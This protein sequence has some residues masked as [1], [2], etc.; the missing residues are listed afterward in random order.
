MYVYQRIIVRCTV[1]GYPVRRED[2]M[3]LFHISDLHLGIKLGGR[4]ISEDMRAI[5]L[6]GVLGTAYEKYRPD[7][8][9]IAGDI[10]DRRTPPEE[11]VALFDEFMHKA[12]GLSLPLYMISGNHDSAERVAYGRGLFG[13]CGVHIS[14]P[15]SDRPPFVSVV[16]AGGVDIA[17]LPNITTEAVNAWFPDEEAQDITAALGAVFRKAGIPREGRPCIL[18]AH[19]ALGNS[20]DA[21]AVGKLRMASPKVF[22]PFAYTALGHYHTPLS[23]GEK[24][25][26]C[27]SPMCFSRKE[28]R[29]PQK[30]IDVID[31]GDNGEVS[32]THEPITPPHPSRIVTG[33]I[34]ELLARGG[35]PCEDYVYITLT[36]GDDIGGYA[37][38][39]SLRYP[40]Y[41]SIDYA[42][43]G[44]C[45]EERQTAGEER[46]MGFDELFGGFFRM[47]YGEEPDGALAELAA[48]LFEESMSKED[49]I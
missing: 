14:Q 44:A 13:R 26:Y 30:Y 4:D 19:Q 40:N 32:V 23:F 36:G 27:G 21:Q 16:E 46:E 28:A 24:A 48:K 42:L 33:T 1:N 25:R 7:G 2:I 5:L 17:L 15:L 22:E 10:Y 43:G 39:L 8:V 45:E 18:V 6:D 47:R 12:A 35:E 37:D 29:S 9:I 11:S 34:E 20:L 31:I 41:I 38:R 49:G 3:R